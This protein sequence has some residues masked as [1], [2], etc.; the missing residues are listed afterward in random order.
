MNCIMIVFLVLWVIFHNTVGYYD[1]LS[2]CDKEGA[3]NAS[4][5][6][7]EDKWYISSDLGYPNITWMIRAYF[8]DEPEVPAGKVAYKLVDLSKE[9]LTEGKYRN[10]TYPHQ[11]KHVCY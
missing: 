5:L 2:L 9:S 1:P 7:I 11:S 6:Y 3:I 10:Q 4:W 8:E